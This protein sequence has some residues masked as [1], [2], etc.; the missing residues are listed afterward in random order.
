MVQEPVRQ[1]ERVPE[2]TIVFDKEMFR[3]ERERS[4]EALNYMEK[5]RRAKEALEED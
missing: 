2:D 3:R 5:L 4:K 1:E